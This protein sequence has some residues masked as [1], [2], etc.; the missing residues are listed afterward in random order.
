MIEIALILGAAIIAGGTIIARY[1]NQIL[2]FM[3]KVIQKLKGKIKGILMGSAVFI[4]RAGDRI[5]NRTKHY[6]KD[7]LGT[8]H[9]KIVT[10]EQKEEEVPSQYRKYATIDD[11]FDLTSELENQIKSNG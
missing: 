11:E 1:W 5:Q 6:A 9:E 10:L 4:K 3:K 7:E 2:S 8:W